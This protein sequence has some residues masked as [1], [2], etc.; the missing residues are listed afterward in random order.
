LRQHGYPEIGESSK[1]KRPASATG[2]PSGLEE[3]DDDIFDDPT[4]APVTQATSSDKVQP[5][6]G[7]QPTFPQLTVRPP[8]SAAP[9]DKTISAP[10][11]ALSAIQS[12]VAKKPKIAGSASPF[13]KVAANLTEVAVGHHS[14]KKLLGLE[15]DLLPMTKEGLMVL[16]KA[17]EYFTGWLAIQCANRLEPN[18]AAKR[19]TIGPS[20]LSSV[21]DTEYCLRFA[22]AGLES[23]CDA[24]T[25]ES[26]AVQ[27]RAARAAALIES[28]KS[29][30]KNSSSPAQQSSPAPSPDVTMIQ[31]D[32]DDEI[33]SSADSPKHAED[34]DNDGIDEDAGDNGF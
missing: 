3:E 20:E 34:D 9:T 15:P 19:S 13:S 4:P 11:S 7:E 25:K 5:L 23:K 32:D 24:A 28:A 10:V 31:D 14:V 16:C 29:N 30:P 26:L 1:R 6:S 33:Q 8:V 12:P 27:R 17:A 2:K 22:L 21:L 18:A